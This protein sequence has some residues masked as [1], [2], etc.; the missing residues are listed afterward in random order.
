MISLF[1]SRRQTLGL[2]KEDHRTIYLYLSHAFETKFILVIIWLFCSYMV[3]VLTKAFS[4]G[5]F[6]NWERENMVI[7]LDKLLCKL[8]LLLKTGNI[9]PKINEFWAKSEISHA[10]KPHIFRIDGARFECTQ[11]K[12]IF[13]HYGFVSWFLM[14]FCMW[15]FT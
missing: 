9:S 15:K 13:L 5:C 14:I 12:H 1:H 10:S 4:I 3:S 8:K 2:Q 11:M 7:K 6:M